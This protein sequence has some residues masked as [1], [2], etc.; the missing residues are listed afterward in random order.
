MREYL[1]G[2]GVGAVWAL[3]KHNVASDR[4]GACRIVDLRSR[5][6]TLTPVFACLLACP[7]RRITRA[8]ELLDKGFALEGLQPNPRSYYHVMRMLVR[9]KR[10]VRALD[11]L[12]TM[13]D[14]GEGGLDS[15]QAGVRVV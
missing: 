3:W 1:G 15:G 6:R 5:L 14:R 2:A 12:N 7:H 10:L 4:A 9:A 11:F 8:M 13:Q